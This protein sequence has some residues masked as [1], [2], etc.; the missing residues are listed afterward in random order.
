LIVLDGV[1]T[2]DGDGLPRQRKAG[3]PCS[4]TAK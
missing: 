3:H 4:P 2:R 1:A